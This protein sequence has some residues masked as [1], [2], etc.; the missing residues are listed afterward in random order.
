MILR[1]SLISPFGRKVRLAA[2]HLGLGPLEVVDTDVFN[3][4]DPIR[5]ENPLGKMPVLT[6]SDGLFIYDSSVILEY[7]DALSGGLLFPGEPEAR[8]AVRQLEALCDGIM[9]AGV[10]IVA[11]RRFRPAEMVYQMWIDYQNE[12]IERAVDKLAICDVDPTVIDAGTIAMACAL[13]WLYFR[14]LANWPEMQPNLR[15]WLQ[16]FADSTSAFAKTDPRETVP[17]PLAS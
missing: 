11:E 6:T 10:A 9:D 1:S 15:C 3:P 17:P 16:D 7:F 13:D 4:L 5:S 2:L 12:K 8:V 14:D